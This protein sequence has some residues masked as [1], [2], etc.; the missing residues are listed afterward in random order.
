MSKNIRF[1]F[2][3]LLLCALLTACGHEHVW[4]DATCQAPKTCADCGIT[5]GAVA[6]HHWNQANC[7]TPKT[8]ADCG[9]VEGTI[10]D[11]NWNNAT[12]LTPKTCADCGT[13]EGTIADHDWNQATCQ[14]PKTCSDCGTTIGSALPHD[15]NDANC[16]TPRT[17]TVCG[18]TEGTKMVHDYGQWE[19]A[20]QDNTGQWFFTRSCMFCGEIQTEQTDGPGTRKDHGSAGFVEGTTVIVSIFANDGSTAW[21]F[22][23]EEDRNTRSIMLKHLDSATDWLTRQIGVYG[24]ESRFIYDWEANPEL[25]Y[26]CDFGNQLLVRQ[27]TGGYWTEESFVL[28]NIPWD[29]LK[30]KY[31][32]QNV[33][34]IIYFNTDE[35]NTVRSWAVSNLDGADTE[36]INMFVRHE[37]SDGFYYM[38]AATF[39]HEILH[40]FGAPDLYYASETIPQSYV[41]YCERTASWDIM[42]STNLGETV[43]HLFTELDAYYLGL[44]DNCEVVNTWGLGKSTFSD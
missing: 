39:A 44:I 1:F 20:R 43:L 38:A 9:P 33:I 11:H 31:Q 19:E 24:V 13:T 2:S 28:E 17:C 6:D 25:Y 10:A 40:C 35:S 23:T 34:Y 21:D 14:A 26:T 30:E 42:F 32:A 29:S 36:I 5:E 7:L 27:D 4:S 3:A 18:S 15:W 37:R 8:C 22:E 16:Q 12:C 41:D